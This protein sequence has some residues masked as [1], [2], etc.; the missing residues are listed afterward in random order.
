MLL[1]TVIFVVIYAH[2]YTPCSQKTFSFVFLHNSRVHYRQ[3]FSGYQSVAYQ[4]RAC[5]AQDEIPIT[6]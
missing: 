5:A 2:N 1:L 4:G 3:S 6:Y